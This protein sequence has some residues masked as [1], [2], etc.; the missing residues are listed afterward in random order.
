MK[1]QVLNNI[2][3]NNSTLNKQNFQTKPSLVQKSV[4]L[5]NN[6]YYPL[7]ISFEGSQAAVYKNLFKYK[8]PCMYT[9]ITMMDSKTALDFI[10]NIYKLKAKEIFD[11]LKDW[12]ASFLHPEFIT[13]SGKD[14]Y[15]IVKEQA[16]KTPDLSLKE[17]FKLLKPQYEKILVK[18]QV[19]ILDTLEAFSYSVPE[20][21]LGDHKSIISEARNRMLG[22]PIK[23][24]F[25]VKEFKYKLEQIKKE[26]ATLKDKKSVN[27]INLLLKECKNFSSKNSKK[28]LIQQRKVVNKLTSMLNIS[29]LQNDEALQNL[30]EDARLRLND[31]KTLVP[32]TK[33][34]FIHDLAKNVENVK[35]KDTR[36]AIM[37]IATKLPTSQDSSNSYIIK[38]ASK[39][40]DKFVYNLLWP[41]IATIEHILPKSCGGAIDDI[42]NFGGA[43][44]KPNSDRHSIT[45][46]E[47]IK[48]KPLTQQNSQKYLNWLIDLAYAGILEKEEIDISCIE[49]FKKQVEEQSQGLITLDSSRLY[50]TGKFKKPELA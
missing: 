23:L 4:A 5:Q 22:K 45:F 26:Y 19:A 32:F 28:T 9:G 43:A 46:I 47:Q 24:E 10:N 39:T 41:I 2:Y 30:F 27:F 48:R 11:F 49:S 13:K 33:K 42:A 40:P 25:S 34:G 12:E 6:F 16:E 14:S 20:E 29:H 21:Y 38:F 15:I 44:A 7:N 8:P 3:F 18:Q 1:I 31:K 36:R 50:K 35:D 37:A 17:I